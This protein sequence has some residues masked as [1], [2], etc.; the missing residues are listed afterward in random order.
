MLLCCCCVAAGRSTVSPALHWTVFSD[1]WQGS[2]SENTSYQT[3]TSTACA[4]VQLSLD[5]CLVESIMQSS[6]YV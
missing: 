3:V 1:L 6:C 5:R 2:S 4:H